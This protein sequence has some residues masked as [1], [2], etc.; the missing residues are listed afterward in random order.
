MCFFLKKVLNCSS[1]D[2]N[3]S[4]PLLWRLLRRIASLKACAQRDEKPK[5]VSCLSFFAF[6]HHNPKLNLEDFLLSKDM[7]QLEV[8]LHACAL[9]ATYVRSISMRAVHSSA[10]HEPLPRHLPI[11]VKSTVILLQSLMFQARNCGRIAKFYS[12]IYMSH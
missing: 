5:N 12:M 1:S 11:G 7:F 3:T 10:F 8:G 6:S 4:V 9:Y 2:S